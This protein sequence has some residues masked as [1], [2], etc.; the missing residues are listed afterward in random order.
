MKVTLELRAGGG[1]GR[2]AQLCF[3]RRPTPLLPVENPHM[4]QSCGRQIGTRTGPAANK[5]ADND[6]QSNLQQMT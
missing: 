5:G 2:R 4:K 3:G 6:S 1:G